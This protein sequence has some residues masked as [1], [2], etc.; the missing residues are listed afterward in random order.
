MNAVQS[1]EAPT[2]A[3]WLQAR[4][5]A[6]G[7][8]DVAAILGMSPFTTAYEVWLDKTNRI[9]DWEGNKSTRAGN[10]F[11]S[12]VLDRAESE[13]G[14]LA[15]NVRLV[16]S[17]L[18]M[19]STLDGQVIATS[20]PVEAKVTGIEGPVFGHWGDALTDDVPNYYLVQMHSQLM[21]TKTELAYLF[22][23]IAGRG[24]VKFQAEPAPK[25]HEII[26]NKVTD[27]WERHIVRGIE[28]PRTDKL[29]LEVVKRL[30]KQ[31]KKSIVFDLATTSL[32][33]HREVLKAQEKEIA[34]QI[35]ASEVQILLALGDAESAT[36]ADGSE[37]TYF[38]R[39]R[40][41]TI[42]KACTYRQIHVKKPKGKK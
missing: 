10:T 41:E 6:I 42:Q 19:A 37:F 40:K 24:V 12:A 27:W 31:A 5:G 39:H 14:P 38:E 36:M 16:H 33:N 26:G 34:E 7:A 4:K 32:V 35:K 1:S 2:R 29:S 15:R 18:P 13:L 8:S 25:L 28:P 30:R 17:D 9:D 21:V 22:A 20:E 23:L 11:E 3:E